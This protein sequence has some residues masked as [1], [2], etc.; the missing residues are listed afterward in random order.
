MGNFLSFR[1][2]VTP[3]IVK[4]LYVLGAIGVVITAFS[5]AYTRPI[6][7]SLFGS[8][9]GKATFNFW[10]FLA[11]LVIGELLWRVFCET[12]IL[13]FQI[14]AELV[15]L[16][17]SKPSSAYPAPT[18]YTQTPVQTSTPWT[19]SACNTQSPAGAAFCKKCGQAKQP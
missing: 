4:V 16:N 8:G 12:M 9:S 7:Y 17:G 14:Q 13:L 1:T 10:V 6:S 18:P 3:A 19:C 15:R 11:V 2:M 5:S